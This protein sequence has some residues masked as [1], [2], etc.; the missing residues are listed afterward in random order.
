MSCA[1]T[2]ERVNVLQLRMAT[3]F[4]VKAKA[5]TALRVLKRHELDTRHWLDDAVLVQAPPTPAEAIEGADACQ[6]GVPLQQNPYPAG[7][8]R[9]EDWAWAWQETEFCLQREQEDD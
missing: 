4:S 3:N 8:K 1:R 6:R 2:S 7:T 9:H 5:V